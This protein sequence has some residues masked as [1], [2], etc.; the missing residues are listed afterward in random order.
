LLSIQKANAKRKILGAK[1]HTEIGLVQQ[2]YPLQ[3]SRRRILSL[4]GP[5]GADTL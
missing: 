1:L 3:H 5:A 2:K 4:V